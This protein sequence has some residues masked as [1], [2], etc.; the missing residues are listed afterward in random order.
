[1]L[2][3]TPIEIEVADDGTLNTFTTELGDELAR[4]DGKLGC[5]HCMTPLTI[6]SFRTECSYQGSPI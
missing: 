6:E 1:M 4:E 5:W 3:L 2:T